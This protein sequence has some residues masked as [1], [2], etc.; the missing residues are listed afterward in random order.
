M[1]RWLKVL[2]SG[3]VSLGI[4]LPAITYF[5]A[6]ATAI[7]Q[8]GT[9]RIVFVGTDEEGTSSGIR[10]VDPNGSS[11]VSL[12]ENRYVYSP[13]WSPDGTQL[14]FMGTGQQSGRPHWDA[15]VM[16]SDGSNLRSVSEQ[17]SVDYPGSVAW[18]PDGTQLIYAS[19]DRSGGIA[20]FYKVNLDGSA[21]ELINLVVPTFLYTGYIAW[22]PDGSQIAFTVS[23]QFDNDGKLYVAN[24]DGSNPHPFPSDDTT[25]SELEWSPDGQRV[26]L[27]TRL[28]FPGVPNTTDEIAVAN[29][30]GSNLQVIAGAPPIF[31]SDASWSPD[32][33][34]IVYIA[35]EAGVESMPNRALWIVNAD[36]SNRY[37]LPTQQLTPFG[38]SWGIIPAELVPPSAPLLIPT[39]GE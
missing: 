4:I 5:T 6:A 30:D 18:S 33:T 32:G 26:V 39:P 1:K 3:C 25:F 31:L 11:D 29:A 19:Y 12:I 34:Q 37:Q 14:A 28:N 38:V 21:E 20:G 17:G 22:S 13:V 2:F 8:T 35:N 15:Y 27:S 24:V 36:G 16:S 23:E 9:P 10:M 7:A